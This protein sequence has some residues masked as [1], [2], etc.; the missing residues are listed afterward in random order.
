M[1]EHLKPNQIRHQLNLSSPVGLDGQFYHGIYYKNG[2]PQISKE[3]QARIDERLAERQL[4]LPDTPI[5]QE[6]PLVGEIYN[7]NGGFNGKK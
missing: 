1:G 2:V 6:L 5:F 4:T 7:I 3:K